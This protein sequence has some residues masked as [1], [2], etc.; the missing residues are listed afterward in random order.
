MRVA[1]STRA[2]IT[3][4]IERASHE[5]DLP[6]RFNDCDLFQR[7]NAFGM[8]GPA[9]RHGGTRNAEHHAAERRGMKPEL[10]GAFRLAPRRR[11]VERDSRTDITRS[12]FDLR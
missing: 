9:P 6:N 8:A 12:R 3:A 10:I 1:R 4:R 2:A 11:T 5:R 7:F